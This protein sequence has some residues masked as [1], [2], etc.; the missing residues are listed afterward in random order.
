MRYTFSLLAGLLLAISLGISYVRAPQKAYTEQYSYQPE[1]GETDFRALYAYIMGRTDS[2]QRDE[3]SDIPRRV[4]RGNRGWSPLEMQSLGVSGLG[5]TAAWIFALPIND[6]ETNSSSDDI[7]E[8]INNEFNLLHDESS[9]FDILYRI[10]DSENNWETLSLRDT[11]EGNNGDFP[12]PFDEGF[13]WLIS[14]TNSD[15]DSVIWGFEIPYGTPI[16]APYDFYMINY[17]D[18]MQAPYPLFDV[19]LGIHAIGYVMTGDSV[20]KLTLGSF[21]RMFCCETVAPATP[22]NEQLH[23]HSSKDT[24]VRRIPR[25]SVIGFAGVS[26][27]PSES[28]KFI[29]RSNFA[30][31]EGES[32][33]KAFLSL[34]LQMAT[35]ADNDDMELLRAG[36][37]VTNL[38][39]INA[40]V[41]LETLY[42]IS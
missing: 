37:S 17:N 9:L 19:S 11:L 25:G 5:A 2:I 13:N 3:C 26:G 41:S 10:S 4:S 31:S 32:Y 38:T 39:W 15:S 29:P 28:D 30:S 22:G 36:N 20:F 16:V 24:R 8:S 12:N 1:R 33:E 35:G 7:Y 14:T 42:H 18:D 23:S 27:I 40:G 6:I 34:S 21:D